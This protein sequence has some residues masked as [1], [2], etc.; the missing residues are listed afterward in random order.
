MALVA[1]DSLNQF[2]VMCGESRYETCG[3][4]FFLDINMGMLL[5][6]ASN[7]LPHLNCVWKYTIFSQFDGANLVTL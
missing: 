7:L 5:L 6:H 4:D 3:I 2:S 1:I